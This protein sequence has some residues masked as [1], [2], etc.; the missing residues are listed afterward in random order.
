M[1]QTLGALLLKR[2]ETI[3]AW[4]LGLFIVFAAGL[5]SLLSLKFLIVPYAWICLTWLIVCVVAAM[6]TR[7]SGW[8]ALAINIAAVLVVLGGF[9]LGLYLLASH[10]LAMRNEFTHAEGSPLRQ[11]EQHD[12]LGYAPTK[13]HRVDWRR[14]SGNRLIFHVSYQIN[15]LGLRTV[16]SSNPDSTDCVLFFGGSFT[17]GAGVNDEETAAHLFGVT[18]GRRFQVLNFGFSGYGPHQMLAM[19]ER[20]ARVQNLRCRPIHV[21]YQGIPQHPPRVSGKFYWDR[22]GPKYLLTEDGDPVYR[23][24]FQRR[25]SFQLFVRTQ[26]EKSFLMRRLQQRVTVE[27]IALTVAVVDKAR[28][29]VKRRYPGCSFHVIF[30][31]ERD[32]QNSDELLAGFRARGLRVHRVGEILPGYDESRRRYQLDPDDLH[33][34]PLANRL[35]ADYISRVIVED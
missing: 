30:W 21:I 2:S 32:N 23:G 17:F 1:R 33:P 5:V 13:G 25:N 18:T 26:V 22:F 24:P 8:R 31:D 11:S 34:N 12:L 7:R 3:N 27:D 14:Y 20:D 19:L 6:R 28:K 9:E 35:V 4:I 16:P 10:R 29:L 15:D